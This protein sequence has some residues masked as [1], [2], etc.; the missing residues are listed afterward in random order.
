MRL[1]CGIIQDLF[2]NW[3]SSQNL[4]TVTTPFDGRSDYGPF[5]EQGIPSGGL[6]TGAE[7][8]KTVKEAKLFGGYVGVPYDPCY[9]RACDGL[10]NLNLKV[11]KQNVEAI[12]VLVHRLAYEEDLASVLLG[13][14]TLTF[15]RE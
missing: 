11:M 9:H 13:E 2:E 12:G 8:V 6:F 3:F 14:K 4:E 5:L 7:H 1:P 15:S 10:T